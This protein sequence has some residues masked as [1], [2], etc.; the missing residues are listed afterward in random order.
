MIPP[1]KYTEGKP[2]YLSQITKQIHILVRGS[3]VS[4]AIIYDL[5]VQKRT[6]QVAYNSTIYVNSYTNIRFLIEI[7]H[8]HYLIF[9]CIND[10]RILLYDARKGKMNGRVEY[11]AGICGHR[12]ISK[13]IRLSIYHIGTK[14][15]VHCRYSEDS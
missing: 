6:F 4:Y 15:F 7:F 8:H 9:H 5:K 1:L 3:F 2:V 14:V 12:T 11:P 13:K 10:H